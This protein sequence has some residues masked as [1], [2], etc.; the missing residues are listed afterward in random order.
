MRVGEIEYIVCKALG[1]L[2]SAQFDE[3]NIPNS[4]ERKYIW[5]N[6]FETEG[7]LLMLQKIPITRSHS[8]KIIEM[9]SEM[10]S[11]LFPELSHDQM[12]I[13]SKEIEHLQSL[14]QDLKDTYGEVNY[15]VNPVGFDIKLPPN[16][17]FS[18]FAKCMKDLDTTFKQCPG[19][20][21]D[22]ESIQ[23]SGVDVGST[24]IAFTIIGVTAAVSYILKNLTAIIDRIIVLRSH[25]ITL[26]QQEEVA[27]LAGMA[28]DNL[29]AIIDSNK[30][31][32]K[33]LEE[34]ALKELC[35]SANVTDPEEKQRY[36][37]SF[38]LLSK[39]MDKGMEI[40]AAIGSSEENKALFPTLEAQALPESVTKLLAEANDIKNE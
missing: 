7:I 10:S 14:L 4:I 1:K 21:N 29:H 24:W 33:Q 13:V 15:E 34:N 3:H 31:I 5:I 17:S 20:K 30:A 18:D 40:H 2:K 27:R 9:V 26:K 11:F 32:L 23:F 8:S 25:K 22:F 16:I 12:E 28:N 35:E 6:W 38:D 19:L 36:H 39:W 37:L